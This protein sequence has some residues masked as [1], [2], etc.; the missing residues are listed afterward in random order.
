MTPADT[1]AL[2]ILN[3]PQAK[4]V[5]FEIP[6]EADSKQDNTLKNQF[7]KKIQSPVNPSLSLRKPSAS[8]FISKL[9][10]SPGQLSNIKSLRAAIEG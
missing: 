1:K 2:S 7:I 10:V 9:D 8:H 5:Q 4:Q 6:S 3:T